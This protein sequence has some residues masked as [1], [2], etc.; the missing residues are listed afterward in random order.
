[1]ALLALYSWFHSY[2]TDWC[3]NSL[4]GCVL[5]LLPGIGWLFTGSGHTPLT[6]IAM[7]WLTVCCFYS[8]LSDWYCSSMAGGVL[9]L[10]TP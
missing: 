9:L 8:H 2:H 6:G 4:A 5:L 7:V 10:L 1:M 3:C